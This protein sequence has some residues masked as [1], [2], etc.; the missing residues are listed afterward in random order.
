MTTAI[1]SVE[2]TRAGPGTVMGQLMREYWI[3]A[4]MCSELARGGAPL[5]LMLLG[6]KL[7]AFRDSAGRLPGDRGRAPSSEPAPRR[8]DPSPGCR[9]RSAVRFRPLHPKQEPS[10][11]TSIF[12]GVNAAV[13]KETGLFQPLCQDRDAHR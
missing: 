3:P 8:N 7:I 2:L 5:R 11:S 1:D 10:Y 13:H 4:L 9:G 12:L 6:E